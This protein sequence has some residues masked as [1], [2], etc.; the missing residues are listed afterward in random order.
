MAQLYLVGIDGSEPSNHAVAYAAEQAASVGAA[1]LLAH[2]IDWSGYDFMGPEELA[3]RHK[4]REAEIAAAEE[5]IMSPAKALAA[6]YGVEAETMVRHGQATEV[7]L[8]LIAERDVSQVFVGR[9]GQS[10]FEALI[11]GSTTNALAQHSPVP[12]TVMP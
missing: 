7:L 4:K 11:F 12:V 3:E 1:L 5:K 6:K 10:R 8:G 9:N 2:V